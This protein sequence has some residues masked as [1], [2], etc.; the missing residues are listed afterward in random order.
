MNRNEKLVD[1]LTDHKKYKFF[2]DNGEI[3]I[4]EKHNY[5]YQIQGNLHILQ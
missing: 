2:F 5:Y 3:I 1:K 4:S